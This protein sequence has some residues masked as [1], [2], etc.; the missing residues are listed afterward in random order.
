VG[1]PPRETGADATAIGT[2]ES[3]RNGNDFIDVVL[4]NEVGD[5]LDAARVQKR[6]T[7]ERRRVG[8]TITIRGKFN[9]RVRSGAGFCRRSRRV[10]LKKVRPGPDRT[11][12]RDRTNRRGVWRI[13]KP[14]AR[15]RFY[16]RAQRKQNANVTC[17]P[18][19]SRTVRRR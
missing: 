9:G 6:V 12:G 15:G 7:L 8:S 17:T 18:A 2:I 4:Q 13:N 1:T 10:V 3:F 14:N 16:A 11:V 5:T 19:R